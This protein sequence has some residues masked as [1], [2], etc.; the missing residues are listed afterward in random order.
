M[1]QDE[2]DRLFNLGMIGPLEYKR[3]K[4]KAARRQFLDEDSSGDNGN[5]RRG[6]VNAN[7]INDPAQQGRAPAWGPKDLGRIDQRANRGGQ[8]REEGIRGRPDARE[9]TA[10]TAQVQDISHFKYSPNWY[11]ENT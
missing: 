11:G 5:A 2:C 9:K 7:A 10:S 3:L 8:N 4:S 1:A 6:A